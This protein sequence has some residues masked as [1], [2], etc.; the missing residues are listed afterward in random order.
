MPAVQTPEK[1][2]L[3]QKQLQSSH[4]RRRGRGRGR[5]GG[6]GG[7][8][9][10]GRGGGGRGSS[11]SCRGRSGSENPEESIV[12]AATL[13]IVTTQEFLM[14]FPAAVAFGQ[15]WGEVCR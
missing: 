13:V 10:S 9:D 2:Q 14:P 3:F 4:R 7:G 1:V 5:G 11:G 8:V 6:G 12:V 15:V